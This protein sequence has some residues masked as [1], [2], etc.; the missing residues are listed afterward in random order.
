M[1]LQ[2]AAI[3][4]CLF[5]KYDISTLY[6][7]C[8]S[9]SHTLSIWDS[10]SPH[11]EPQKLIHPLQKG[12][13]GMWAPTHVLTPEIEH[14]PLQPNP[15][16]SWP[17]NVM[18]LVYNIHGYYIQG[19]YTIVK[20][21]LCLT[22]FYNDFV[23]GP[24]RRSVQYGVPMIYQNHPRKRRGEKRVPN[25][26]QENGVVNCSYYLHE[27]NPNQLKQMKYLNVSGH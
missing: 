5:H 25:P 20:L 11:M 23:C 21:E 8:R 3:N 7:L 16:V 17:P 15:T 14:V 13:S 26:S 2:E 9:V 18:L 1:D 4:E 27:S 24:H 22:N 19:S 6:A 12:W 10:K